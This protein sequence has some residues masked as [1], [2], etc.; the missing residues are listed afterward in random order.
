M[1][2]LTYTGAVLLCYQAACSYALAVRD[3]SRPTAT[4]DTGILVGTTVSEPTISSAINK[5]LGIPFAKPPARWELPTKAESWQGS[6]D[7]TQFGNACHQLFSTHAKNADLMQK[8]FNSPPATVPGDED[9]LYLNVFAPS[10]ATPG[11]NK[12]VMFW[13]HG[14]SNMIGTGALPLYEASQIAGNQDVI[15]ITTNYRL[16]LF[17]FPPS[18]DIPKREKNLGFHDQRLALNWVQRNIRSFGGDPS[19]VTIFGESAGGGAV[20]NLIT[21]PP[22]PLPFAAAIAQSLGLEQSSDPV[23]KDKTAWRT[24]VS[25]TNC[26]SA[27]NVLECMRNVPASQLLK[28]ADDNNLTFAPSPDSGVTFANS[29]ST[30]RGASVL[31][32]KAVARVP[33]LIGS[34]ANEA[35]PFLAGGNSL[36]DLMAGYLGTATS[37][38]FLQIYRPKYKGFATPEQRDEAL[39]TEAIMTCPAARTARDSTAARIP[40]WRYYYNASFPNTEI[41]PGDGAYHSAEIAP[42]FGT[43]PRKGATPFQGETSRA[44]QKIWADFAKNPKEGPGWPRAPSIQVLGGGARP[45]QSDEGR[46]VSVTVPASEVDARCGMYSSVYDAIQLGGVLKAIVDALLGVH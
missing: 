39:A 41:V 20:D 7:A 4:I 5:F 9:C 43:Y 21:A 24:L 31:N 33:F 15:V 18:P 2:K 3:N 19:R 22:N 35:S 1:V 17:G 42:I 12:A 29:I 32:H 23:E 40:T 25:N 44:M 45:G 34:N 16:N 27:G 10:S 37:K 36:D 28:T 6:R 30:R 11:S 14:G 8:Y 38:L 13:I 26:G 46:S